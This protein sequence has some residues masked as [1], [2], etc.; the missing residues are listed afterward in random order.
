MWNLLIGY[1]KEKNLMES[2]TSL[3][4]HMLT[5]PSWTLLRLFGR[6]LWEPTRFWK[7]AEN[8]M[9]LDIIRFPRMKSMAISVIQFQE[10]I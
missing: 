5:D 2:S 7:H 9:S 3:R 1:L 10:K 4:K 6:I 8:I